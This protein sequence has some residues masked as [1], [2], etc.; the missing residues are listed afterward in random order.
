MKIDLDKMGSV[1]VPA[2][3]WVIDE[4]LDDIIMAQFVDIVD[5]E[6]ISRNGVLVKLDVAKQLWR[7]GKVLK[8]GP[9]CN[10]KIK[11]GVHVLFPNDRGIHVPKV[12][13]LTNICFINEERIFG[14]VSSAKIEEKKRALK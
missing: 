5:G 11:P 12:G 3:D 9:E 10:E 8:V 2:L 6:Y 13:G 7:V 14:I 1:E 4:V